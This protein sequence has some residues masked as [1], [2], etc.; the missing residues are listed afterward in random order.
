M[1]DGW[2]NATVGSDLHFRFRMLLK[3]AVMEVSPSRGSSVINT[4]YAHFV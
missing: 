1:I 2:E 4:L 3:G